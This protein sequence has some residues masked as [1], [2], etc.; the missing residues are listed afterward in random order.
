MNDINQLK[1]DLEDERQRSTKLE[2]LT[3]AQSSN[4]SP[5]L[6]SKDIQSIIFL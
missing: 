6:D 4:S 3:F 5:N 1:T 2:E